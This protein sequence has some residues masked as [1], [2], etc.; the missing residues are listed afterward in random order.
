MEDTF[1]THFTVPNNCSI[2]EL[3][4][5]TVLASWAFYYDI[6]MYF[7]MSLYFQTVIILGILF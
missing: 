4:I 6:I 5:P 1:F 7:D 3:F 2:F